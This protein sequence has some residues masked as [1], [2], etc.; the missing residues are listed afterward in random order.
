MVLLGLIVLCLGMTFLGIRVR[1][2]L[3]PWLAGL[4]WW[5][6]AFYIKSNPPGSVEEGSSVHTMLFIVAL[7]IGIAVPLFIL[8]RETRQVHQIEGG[9]SVSED[10]GG[11]HMPN[12]T[13]GPEAKRRQKR[14][15]RMNDLEDYKQRFNDALNPDDRKRRR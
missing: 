8:W 10:I 5:A 4:C 9:H 1:Y 14:E 2:P 12:W 13:K 6:L 15:Q 7:G 3:L 11:W